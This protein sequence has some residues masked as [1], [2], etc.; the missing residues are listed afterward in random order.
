[1]PQNELKYR[2]SR[3]NNPSVFNKDPYL[4][5]LLGYRAILTGIALY[6]AISKPFEAMLTALLV[7]GVLLFIGE[8]VYKGMLA[9][10]QRK[11]Y[12]LKEQELREKRAEEARQRFEAFQRAQQESAKVFETLE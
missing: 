10:E 12:A 9:Y 4:P 2:L 5:W 8:V 6:S 7:L 1:M 11:L 3:F